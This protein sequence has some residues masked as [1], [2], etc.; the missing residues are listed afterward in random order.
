[1]NI[2]VLPGEEETNSRENLP[3]T[4][5]SKVYTLKDEDP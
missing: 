3:D 1:M 4:I 2:K 5:V